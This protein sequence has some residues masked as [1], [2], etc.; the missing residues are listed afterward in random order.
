MESLMSRRQQR[1]ALL[2][3]M[4]DAK[5]AQAG[6]LEQRPGKS[7]DELHS[8][9]VYEAEELEGRAKQFEE[10]TPGRL[11]AQTIRQR[12][13]KLWNWVRQR[14]LRLAGSNQD[15]SASSH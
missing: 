6:Q 15:D 5:R 14:F 2:R 4:A 13:Q 3:Q 9:L 7:Q 8:K 1:S 12:I 11:A 10:T